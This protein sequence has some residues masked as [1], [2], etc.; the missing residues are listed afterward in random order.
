MQSFHSFLGVF[1]GAESGQAEK[2]FAVLA[3]AAAGSTHH[4]R[5]G[6]QCVKKVP[7]GH[8]L[9]ARQPHIRRVLSA[10]MPNTQLSQY[11][12]HQLGIAL[13]YRQL[14]TALL[15]HRLLQSGKTYRSLAV[16]LQAASLAEVSFYTDVHGEP[17]ISASMSV[18]C[19]RFPS[20]RQPQLLL[21]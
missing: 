8:S 13:I 17:A 19:L 10:N 2:A 18:L 14:L 6:Q 4:M 16:L 7:R 12:G 3:K 5:M 20:Q 15:P 1:G 21:L 9:R 11:F